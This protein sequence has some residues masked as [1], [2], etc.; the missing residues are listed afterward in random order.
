MDAFEYLIVCFSKWSEAKP[1]HDKS[2]SIVV[3]INDQG[4]E[5]V[6]EVAD[7]LHS[8]TGTQQRVTSAYLPQSTGLV[9]RQNGTI[10]NVLVMVLDQN[11][12][13]W[14]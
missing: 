13:Q 14:S 5:F 4:R 2:A 9:E 3:Q 1:I 10:K 7:K 11:R 6:N 12:K 8:M